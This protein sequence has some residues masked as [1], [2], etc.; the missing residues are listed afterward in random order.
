[1]S[2]L[3]RWESL[4][5]ELAAK[6]LLAGSEEWRVINCWVWTELY[7]DPPEHWRRDLPDV[8]DRGRELYRVFG[9][10]FERLYLAESGRGPAWVRQEL[11]Q[12]FGFAAEPAVEAVLNRVR[13]R[14]PHLLR[15]F[16]RK[17]HASLFRPLVLQERWVRGYLRRVAHVESKRLPAAELGVVNGR[18]P[19]LLD[20]WPFPLGGEADG[21]D[22][23]RRA[24][25]LAE[26]WCGAN[27][28]SRGQ[29]LEGLVSLLLGWLTKDR[30]LEERCRD[31]LAEKLPDWEKRWDELVRRLRPLLDRQGQLETWLRTGWDWAE[32]ER[33]EGELA[34]VCEKLN[35]QR[36][37]MERHVARL[38][39][40]PREVQHLL[41]QVV[42]QKVGSLRFARIDREIELMEERVRGG[43]ADL[44]KRFG[45]DLPGPCLALVADVDAHTAAR[46][47]SP[48]KHNVHPAR[49]DALRR[50][51]AE[52]LAQAVEVLRAARR[53]LDR[54]LHEPPGPVAMEE[55]LLGWLGDVQDLYEFGILDRVGVAAGLNR[56][57]GWRLDRLL[58]GRP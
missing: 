16:K 5:K 46:P 56:R 6:G 40:R 10:E 39:P 54:A 29:R 9:G 33:L 15:A 25:Q 27:G 19:D 21:E 52:W 34:E 44:C 38:F 48:R 3:H 8:V 7:H 47:E 1:M 53:E 49:R 30:T 22:Y 11:R 58:R 43:A 17:Y 32:R 50:A 45:A 20:L 31:Y 55:A 36:E 57:R 42:E 4:G 2:R 23:G 51:N 14:R 18:S 24:R 26:L 37:R 35:R 28:F 12:R 41:R 13:D